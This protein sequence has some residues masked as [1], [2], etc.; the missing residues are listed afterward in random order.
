[1]KV[2]KSGKEEQRARNPKFFK[3]LKNPQIRGSSKIQK[4]NEICTKKQVEEVI[5]SNL[6]KFGEVW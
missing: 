2:I 3:N 4:T 6:A 5:W 1:M